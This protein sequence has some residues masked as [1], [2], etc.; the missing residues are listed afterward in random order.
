VRL[1]HFTTDSGYEQI[2]TDRSADWT[3]W[4]FRHGV[5]L[6]EGTSTEG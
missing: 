6:P 1:F 2:A 4:G 3:A 5:E